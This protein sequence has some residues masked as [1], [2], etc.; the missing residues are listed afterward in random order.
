M[1]P[2]FKGIKHFALDM[3]GTIYEGG[4][5]FPTTRPF[6]EFLESR[7]LGHTFLTNNSSRSVDAYLRHLRGMGLS[8]RRGEL[9]SSTLN[10]VEHLR[11]RHPAVHRLFILGTESMRLEMVGQGF[12]DVGE[13]PDAVVVG[14]DRE[15]TYERLCAAAYWISRGLPFISTHPDTVCPTSEATLLVD[16]GCLTSCLEKATGREAVVLGKPDPSMLRAVARRNNLA[17]SEIAMVGDR[18]NTDI[19]M[20]RRAGTLGV[21]VSSGPPRADCLTVRDLGELAGLLAKSV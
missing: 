6:L 10:T 14:F 4:R 15:L 8:A 18:L 19:E 9:Y 11:E 2:P 5:L 20:A 17:L 7:G 21:L 12:E 13:G 3:D 16:C 1:N